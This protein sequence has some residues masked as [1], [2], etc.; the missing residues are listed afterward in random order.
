MTAIL[1]V[2]AVFLVGKPILYVSFKS[3]YLLLVAELLFQNQKT[4]FQS[5]LGVA[6][7]VGS[8]GRGM[9]STHAMDAFAERFGHVFAEVYSCF[10]VE[11]ACGAEAYFD[12]SVFLSD[13]DG[14]VGSEVYEGSGC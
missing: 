7:A 11:F 9:S 12:V 3:S 6:C 14:Y 1:L 13:D 2:P 8:R 10:C 5:D 4:P